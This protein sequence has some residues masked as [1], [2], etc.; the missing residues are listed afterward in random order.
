MF[1]RLFGK[2]IAGKEASF[3][4][5]NLQN[6]LQRI[7]DR[8]N[9]IDP[10]LAEIDA[11][12]DLRRQLFTLAG[13][14]EN[15]NGNFHIKKS[16]LGTDLVTED[17]HVAFTLGAGE[18]ALYFI[19]MDF[20]KGKMIYKSTPLSKVSNEMGFRIALEAFILFEPSADEIK[21]ISRE[22]LETKMKEPRAADSSRYDLIKKVKDDKLQKP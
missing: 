19:K 6:E 16:S 1:E 14:P 7:A 9:N 8:V 11:T 13:L 22:T 15:S 10:S 12:R 5:T 2:K 18:N 4:E 17:G 20:E 21:D 3:A